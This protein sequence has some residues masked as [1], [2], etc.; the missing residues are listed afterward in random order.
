MYTVTTD[1]ESQQ[2]VDAL[3]AHA[4]AP[5]AELRTMLEVAP[6]NGALFNQLKPDSPMRTCAFGPNT[7]GLAVY[8]IWRTS[9]ALTWSRSSEWADRNSSSDP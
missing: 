4:L 6:W 5:F 7:E 8:L 9:A 3:P 1:A 2:Q